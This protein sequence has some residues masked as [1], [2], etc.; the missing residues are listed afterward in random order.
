MKLEKLLILL[1]FLG[2][3]DK[4]NNTPSPILT[5][6]E[7]GQVTVKRIIFCWQ[8]VKVSLGSNSRNKFE[9]EI[10]ITTHNNIFN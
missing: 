2:Y 10:L 7:N 6:H 9:K 1:L 5:P 4:A 8:L 3:L